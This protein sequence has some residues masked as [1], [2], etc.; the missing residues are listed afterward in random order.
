M[1]QARALVAGLVVTLVVIALAV[2]MV[3]AT[4]LGMIA[5]PTRADLWT[6]VGA[7]VL[8]LAIGAAGAALHLR[9]DLGPGVQ[10]VPERLLEGAPLMAP[11]LFRNMGIVGLVAL[12]P[13]Y[14]A[15]DAA[16]E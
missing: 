16:T 1:R 8:L 3:V 13:E 12:L 14:E 5:R 10:I 6:Y 2:A 9:L 7:M 11:L 15:A 4:A